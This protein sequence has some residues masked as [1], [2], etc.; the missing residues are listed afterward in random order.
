VRNSIENKSLG[1]GVIL[2]N[3]DLSLPEIDDEF[4]DAIQGPDS[5]KLDVSVKPAENDYN[6]ENLN[7]KPMFSDVDYWKIPPTGDLEDIL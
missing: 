6:S 7:T 2:V 1:Q 3:N 5:P 4:Y